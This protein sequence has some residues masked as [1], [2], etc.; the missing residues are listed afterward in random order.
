MIKGLKKVIFY[1]ILLGIFSQENY[2]AQAIFKEVLRTDKVVEVTGNGSIEKEYIVSDSKGEVFLFFPA[3]TRV[4]F[5]RSRNDYNGFIFPPNILLS[6]EIKTPNEKFEKLLSFEIIGQSGDQ[7]NFIEPSYKKPY[8]VQRL[9]SLYK[10]YSGE[11]ITRHK[12]FL[13]GVEDKRLGGVEVVI[14]FDNKDIVKPILWEYRGLDRLNGKKDKNDSIVTDQKEDSSQEKTTNQQKLKLKAQKINKA[15]K[16]FGEK[17][18]WVRR[19][20]LVEEIDKDTK[21]FRS[22][23]YST[24]IFVLFDEAPA[25]RH[26]TGPPA[27]KET[28]VELAEF[29]PYALLPKEQIALWSRYILSTMPDISTQERPRDYSFLQSEN[30]YD[31]KIATKGGGV[32]PS[33]ED[34]ITYNDEICK[35]P[36]LASSPIVIAQGICPKNTSKKSKTGNKIP[37]MTNNFDLKIDANNPLIVGPRALKKN[38]KNNSTQEIPSSTKNQGNLNSNSLLQKNENN[39]T[40]NQNNID[41]NLTSFNQ[42]SLAPTLQASSF[43]KA[44]NSSDKQK[45]SPF[46]RFFLFFSIGIFITGL[47]IISSSKKNKK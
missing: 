30:F 18:L 43:E 25:K 12:Y 46:F 26:N 42:Q 29:G 39:P 4:I 38:N 2:F 33:V 27:T 6:E 13:G 23:I 11:K 1:I 41:E 17:S 44:I 24:G 5:K 32:V 35:D 10:K 37:S 45:D 19:G 15:I 22:I 14:P 47:W 3:R 8:K 40:E 28:N 20:G 7:L 21:V 36:L 9:Y 16:S 31:K 34:S